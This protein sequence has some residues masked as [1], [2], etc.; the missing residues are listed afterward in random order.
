M[1][2]TTTSTTSRKKAPQK[3]KAAAAPKRTEMPQEPAPLTAEEREKMIQVAAYHLA[4]RDGF[5]PGKERDYW[6]QAERE[7]NAM[8]N[9]DLH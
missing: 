4:E 1:A 9:T 2:K 3:T 8:V 6:L 7:I 5:Q